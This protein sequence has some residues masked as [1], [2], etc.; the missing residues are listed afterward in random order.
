MLAYS[1]VTLIYC[2]GGEFTDGLI[3]AAA[4]LLE[5]V[6][7]PALGCSV[8]LPG[9]RRG[10]AATGLVLAARPLAAFMPRSF[11]PRWHWHL[12]SPPGDRQVKVPAPAAPATMPAPG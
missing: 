6:P 12:R 10:S 5:H 8:A 1:S 7:A 3:P 9:T 4:E 2:H 11:I